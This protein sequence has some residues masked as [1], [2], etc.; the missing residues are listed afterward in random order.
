MEL[1]RKTWGRELAEK[2]R[3]DLYQKQAIQ[4]KD[5]LLMQSRRRMNFNAL[6]RD[7]GQKQDLRAARLA[8]AMPLYHSHS[9]PGHL[10]TEAHK[11]RHQQP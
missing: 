10:L 2:K 3:R 7:F 9:A 11:N 5:S 4:G 8:F 6:G 1:P